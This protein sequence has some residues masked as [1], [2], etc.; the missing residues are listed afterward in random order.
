MRRNV[1]R[2]TFVRA[3]GLACVVGVLAAFGTYTGPANF[4]GG[5]LPTP[6]GG[7]GVFVAKYSP[8]G[9]HLW[10]RTLGDASNGFNSVAVHG[11][12]VVVMSNLIRPLTFGG[13]T[14]RPEGDEAR[15]LL[16]ART[17]PA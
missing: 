7:S 17:V 11:N 14:F 10:S 16:L 4:G 9:K 13:E 15:G 6:T 8:D 2:D 5:P 12:R 3:A 1:R